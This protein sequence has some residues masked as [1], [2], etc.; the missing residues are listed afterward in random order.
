MEWLTQVF[1]TP[2]PALIVFKLYGAKIP[3]YLQLVFPAAVLISCLIVLGAMNRH[4]E[5]VALQAMGHRRRSIIFPLFFAIILASA[6]Y[7]F[8][9]TYLA[10]VGLR[11]HYTILDE[12]V[13]HR[14][15]RFSQFRQEKIWYRNQDILYNVGFFDLD[16]S[17]LYDVTL[18]T[19]DDDFHVAQTLYAQRAVWRDLSDENPGLDGYW[20]LE[21]GVIT[22]TDKRLDVPVM[23]KF[24]RRSSRL[25]EGPKNLRQFEFNAD[26]MT[27][28][29]LAQNI[30]KYKKLGINTAEWEATFHKRLS[31]MLISF[32]FVL[33]ALPK[34]LK[35][36]RGGSPIW[37]ILLAVVVCFVY[38]IIF[39]WAINLGEQSKIHPAVSAWMPS[40]LFLLAITFYN[41]RAAKA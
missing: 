33:L 6:P 11:A 9:A 1:R 40:V 32:V 5:V 41:R 38:W 17:E 12:D 35:F 4:L 19:F 20:N 16:K 36:N 39:S 14:P 18:Y 34:A 25:I 7:F 30:K 23:Q 31:F 28:I 27:Q 13:F 26:T 10:P 21:E 37:D 8:V 29:Q 22:L 24:K 2:A 3:V 15:S